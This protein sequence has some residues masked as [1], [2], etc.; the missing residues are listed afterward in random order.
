MG[1]GCHSWVLVVTHTHCHAGGDE[2]LSICGQLC[3]LVV[4]IGMVVGV[5][6]GVGRWS[7]LMACYCGWLSSFVLVV[8]VGSCCG[9]H[10]SW[11]W[12]FVGGCHLVQVHW[13]RGLLWV[14]MA[15]QWEVVVGTCFCLGVSWLWSWVAVV[16]VC[17][18]LVVVH[19]CHLLLSRCHITNSDVIP[20]IFNC[21]LVVI[22]VCY[23]VV[24]AIVGWCGFIVVF[25]VI[26][27]VVEREEH[28]ICLVMGVK[29][30]NTCCHQ[31]NNW[32][33]L[34]SVPVNSVNHSSLNSGIL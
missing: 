23:W 24:M 10:C 18:W 8:V 5:A 33:L 17:L 1:C 11:W 7:L 20:G 28:C 2:S 12:W 30:I 25:V 14:V 4:V 21:F 15:C 22:T 19:H 31:P 16:G 9:V 34:H 26:N 3:M 13:C 6:M 27:V 32:T 29:Q